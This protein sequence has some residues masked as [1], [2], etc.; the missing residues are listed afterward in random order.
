MAW[1]SVKADAHFKGTVR[2]IK[3][4]DWYAEFIFKDKLQVA[5]LSQARIMSVYRLY[6]KMGAT[7]DSDL[8]LVREAF[9]KL[10]F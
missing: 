2:T 7:P 4:G 1:C 9:R 8:E 6:K 5:V 3:E 10:Y